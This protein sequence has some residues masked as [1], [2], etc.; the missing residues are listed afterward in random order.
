MSLVRAKGN[1]STEVKFRLALVRAH[2]RGW[3]LHTR[4]VPGVPDFYFPK[5]KAAIF[6]DGCFWHGCPKCCRM[7]EQNRLYWR[8]KIQGNISRDRKLNQL[9]RR[10]GVRVF[11]IWEHE[12]G[13]S[14]RVRII[15]NSLAQSRLHG[16]K[17]KDS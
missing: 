7:P 3:V 9:L 1:R 15:V 17:R 6:V 5:A 13:D 14:E 10:N 4:E 12:V 11:R 16:S 2:I 8:C